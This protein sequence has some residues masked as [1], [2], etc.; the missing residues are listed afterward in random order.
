MRVLYIGGT[1]EISF[2]CVKRSVEA[3]QE[4]A[5]FNRGRSD[6]PLP[7]GV[8]RI[9]GDL[10]DDAAYAALAEENFDAV[11]QFLC[12]KPQQAERD[13]RTFAGHC[14][15]YVFIS[16]ASCYQKPAPS[17]V[18]TE[19][20]PV[21]N[22]YN[23]YSHNKILCENVFRTAHA[24]G[25]FP[26]TIVRPSHT[27]ARRFPGGCGDSDERAWRIL[28]GRPIIIHGDGTSL[29]TYTH[30]SDFAVPFVGLLGNVAALGEAFHITRHMEAFTWNR[31]AEAM[32]RALGVEARIVHVPTDTLV[33][34][35][36]GMKASLLGDKM[37]P[38]LFDNSKV[39]RVAGE[40]TCRVGLEDGLAAVAEYWLVNRRDAYEPDRNKH[41]LID[42]IAEEQEA[43]G[44]TKDN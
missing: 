34:F 13:V 1:G 38:V 33:R 16:S 27:F 4:V 28:N 10:T 3:G 42:R 19:A 26:A 8:R 12:F 14:G 11:C 41:A 35:L 30:S 22:P 40:F 5:V 9:V 32:G 29:W 31:I 18:I 21:E 17:Y 7:A 2:D 24:E 20:T 15:Q 36:P 23:D 43:L 44:S 25:K 6:L 37:W 39:M